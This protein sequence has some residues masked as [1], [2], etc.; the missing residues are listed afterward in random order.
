MEDNILLCREKKIVEVSTGEIKFGYPNTI[1]TVS[2]I[3]SCIAVAAY[4][5]NKHIGALAHIMLPGIAPVHIKR[6][7]T[8]YVYNALDFMLKTFYK[9]GMGDVEEIEVAMVG[10][11][12]VLQR[13][14]DDIGESNIKSVIEYIN[15][16]NLKIVAKS[17]GGILRRSIMFDISTGE[18]FF[19]I[20]DAPKKFL[21][22]FHNS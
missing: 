12:N 21:C 22:R 18:V 10:G 13:E 3:G 8:K 17:L 9:C 20:G 5:V 16:K 19:S 4:N 14:D 1:L 2:A 7:K 11:A 6:N 15:R